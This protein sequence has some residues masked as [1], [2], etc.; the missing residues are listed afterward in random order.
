MIRKTHS[1][2]ACSTLVGR[3]RRA[4][5]LLAK[6]FESFPV[7][8]FANRNSPLTKSRPYFSLFLI[9]PSTLVATTRIA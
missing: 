6:T 4:R 8:Q 5:R 9:P 1:D 7:N 2:R 3:D